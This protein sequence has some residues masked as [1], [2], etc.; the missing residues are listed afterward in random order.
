MKELSYSFRETRG[1][2][3]PLGTA[4]NEFTLLEQ[5]KGLRNLRKSVSSSFGYIL[6]VVNLFS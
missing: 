6:C 3:K 2:K 4:G 1:N 5:K